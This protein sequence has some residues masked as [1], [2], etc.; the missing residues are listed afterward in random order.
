MAIPF[1]EVVDAMYAIE[2]DAQSVKRPRLA[3]TPTGMRLRH[4]NNKGRKMTVER[5]YFPAG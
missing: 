5:I 4:G 3:V 2:G 1:D